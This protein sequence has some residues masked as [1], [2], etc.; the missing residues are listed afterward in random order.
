MAKKNRTTREA[1]IHVL[2]RS[3][4]VMTTKEIVKAAT[5]F[6]TGLQGKTKDHTIYTTT[7]SES[8]KPNGMIVQVEPGKYRI[9]TQDEIAAMNVV[10]EEPTPEPETAEVEEPKAEEKVEAEAVEV[11]PDP[12]PTA[13][14]RR[15]RSTARQPKQAT[16]A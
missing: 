16:P 15:T 14:K 12:K 11:E 2:Q 13:V 3:G 8:K 4:E 7:L 1:V 5:P 10:A 6:A 9:K